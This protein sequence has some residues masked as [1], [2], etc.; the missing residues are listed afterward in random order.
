MRFKLCTLFNPLPNELLLIFRQLLHVA[1]VRRHGVALTIGGQAVP[2][3][4]RL[5]IAWDNS[6]ISAEVARGSCECIQT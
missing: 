1:I 2:K 3:F 4:A 5:H 6:G